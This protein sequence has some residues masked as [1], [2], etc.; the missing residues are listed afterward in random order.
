MP[1]DLK[2][3]GNALMLGRT[4]MAHLESE[5]ADTLYV[6]GPRDFVF[7]PYKKSEDCRQDCEAHVRRQLKKAGA[8]V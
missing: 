6:L 1:V 8:D 2:W 4:K 7:K 3:K 5:G